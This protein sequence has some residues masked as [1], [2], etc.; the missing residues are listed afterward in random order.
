MSNNKGEPDVERGTCFQEMMRCYTLISKRTQ[1]SMTRTETNAVPT[2]FF[3]HELP[4]A[5]I[6]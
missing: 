2:P 3:I 1:S 5:T 4:K 6:G